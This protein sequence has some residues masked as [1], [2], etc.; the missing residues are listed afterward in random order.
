MREITDSGRRTAFITGA[1]YGIG[2][3]IAVA[4]ARDAFDVAVADLGTE[5]LADTVSK[6]EAIGRRA[7][8]V[9]LD[10]RSHAGIVD[11][12]AVAVGALGKLDVLVNNAGIPLMKPALDITPMEWEA[13]ISVNL[14]GTFFISQEMGRYLI[15][16]KRSG[17]IISIASTHGIIGS[18]G[19]AAYGT[20]K[21]AVIQ[22]TRMLAIEWAEF[23][24]CVNAIAP[25]KVDT[26]SPSRQASVADAAAR[27][28]M[29]AR[30]PLRRFATSEEVAAM[31]CYL[32]SPQ[33]AYITGQTLTL[34]GGLTA[35]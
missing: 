24:V 9:A 4:L 32:A 28:R 12:L 3:A 29:L 21:G 14:T 26:P 7:V 25:G 1:S 18:A 8:P 27:E 31:A 30:I 2:A 35:N 23:G 5:M 34:D 15:N 33:A 10:L 13:V 19:Q 17:S 16:S 22:M 6:I 11:A 20:S